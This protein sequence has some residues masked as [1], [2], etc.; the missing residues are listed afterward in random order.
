MAEGKKDILEFPLEDL[1]I[2]QAIVLMMQAATLC[3]SFNEHDDSL[4]ETS[5]DLDRL[6]LL[7]EKLEARIQDDLDAA[8]AVRL[9]AVEEDAPNEGP[10]SDV[11]GH[12]VTLFSEFVEEAQE[13]CITRVMVDNLVFGLL[14]NERVRTDPDTM[15]VTTCIKRWGHQHEHT[16]MEGNIR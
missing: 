7:A 9:E 10:Y 3:V 2:P 14:C 1:S 12:K 8:N 11:E 5:T 16:D 15:E 4:P 13:V 6:Q